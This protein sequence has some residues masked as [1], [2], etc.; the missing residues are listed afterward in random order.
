MASRNLGTLTLDL[1]LKMA[2]FES[3]MDKA[4]RIAKKQAH[5]ISASMIAVGTTMGHF[6]TEALEGIAHFVEGTV[7]T[8]VEMA[9]LVEKTGLSAKALGG[10]RLAAAQSGVEMESLGKMVTKVAGIQFDA[11][12]GSKVA[13]AE[14]KYFGIT[15][16]DTA[17]QAVDKLIKGFNQ[18]PP[19]FDRAGL[20][21]KIFGQRLGTDFLLVADK[22]KGGLS[23]L[24]KQAEKLGV[25][26]DEGTLKAAEEFD[27]TLSVLHLQMQAFGE[28]IA[29]AV[30]PKL[31]GLILAYQANTGEGEKLRDISSG[32][33]TFLSG[34]GTAALVAV[35]GVKAL[36]SA[37]IGLY[38]ILSGLSKLNLPGYIA[39][40]IS[41]QGPGADFA[42]AGIAFDQVKDAG[43]DARTL[44]GFD[45]LGLGTNATPYTP[46]NTTSG[47]PN[48][49]GHHS[50]AATQ[51]QK[52]AYEELLKALNAL[53]GGHEKHAKSLTAEENAA[54]R[55]KEQLDSL[56]G[57]L[58]GPMEQAQAQA[59]RQLDE[60][61]KLAK[62][63]KISA[64]DLAKANAA[65]A[66]SF[67]RAKDAIQ[68]QAAGPLQEENYQYKEHIRL[69][70]DAKLSQD[71]EAASLKRLSHE[72]DVNVASIKRELDPLGSLLDDMQFELSLVGKTNAE[73]SISNDLRDAEIGMTK[74]QAAAFEKEHAA[75]ITAIKDTEN[76]IEAQQKQI[77]YL[78][79]FRQG[80]AQN[81]EDVITGTES[82]GDA[83]KNMGKIILDEI[84]KILAT[85]LTDSL[86]GKQG[87]AG[88]GS[89]GGWLSSI[90]SFFS[91]GF[92]GGASTS[93]PDFNTF[94]FGGITPPPGYAG[95]TPFSS[96]G[97]AVVGEKGP[98]LLRLPGGS[99]VIP[100]HKM[101]EVAGR[102]IVQNNYFS[103]D[104][105]SDNRSE[106]QI[107]RSAG[108]A[109][110][111]AR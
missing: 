85:N 62:E 82:I 35:D 83:F 11:A 77:S 1:V 40:K 8:S 106:R 72:H 34:V 71:E 48:G 14:M 18:L 16:K 39:A 69:L 64:A 43:R 107:A 7:K 68:A 17:D 111:M 10:L 74:E 81:V 13:A 86:F 88:G 4:S 102:S 109:I 80:F 104:R 22:T 108:R 65:V 61:A 79:D 59:N 103:P 98:E 45:P 70:K 93:M 99:Q 54:M 100:H 30:L 25:Q 21:V 33:A 32:L 91:S 55:F 52:T 58:A 26:L 15:A 94:G 2:G 90:F 53:T 5:E 92:G 44:T 57:A 101:G 50:D 95:G 19:S 20:A 9:H 49:R 75:Q 56:E 41:G 89:G 42:A 37:A 60:F 6:L 105:R 78:D 87:T 36:T 27:K 66:E 97:W 96:A 84:A 38:N 110:R 23:D 73:R 47:S 28:A 63:G 76:A 3:G 31:E 29:T 67:A 24:E 51:Q 12:S 46:E